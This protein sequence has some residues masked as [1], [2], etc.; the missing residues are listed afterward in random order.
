MQ[1]SAAT[2]NTIF[3]LW[4][5]ILPFRDFILKDTGGPRPAYFYLITIIHAISG[6]L[7]IPFGLF[8]VMRGNNLVPSPL[9]FR[10]YRLF[11]RVAYGLYI[12]ATLA[13]VVVYIT[14]FII[15]SNPP[16]FE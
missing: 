6:A 14:W 8:V 15:I 11:M 13:G 10:N 1:T 5:M 3:V 4:M 12:L 7:A 9:R 16:V 2:L